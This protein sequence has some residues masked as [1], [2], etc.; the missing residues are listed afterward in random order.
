M[1]VLPINTSF[2]QSIVICDS[3]TIAASA[4]RSSPGLRDKVYVRSGK[5][6]TNRSTPVF[7]RTTTAERSS[8]TITGDHSK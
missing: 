7:T 5:Q 4:T 3:S 1:H 2:K 6:R 8:L